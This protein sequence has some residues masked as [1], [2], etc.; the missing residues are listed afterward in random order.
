M[1]S[2]PPTVPCATRWPPSRRPRSRV[3]GCSRQRRSRR[4]CPLRRR[5]GEAQG[6]GVGSGGAG[7]REARL[8]AVE[9]SQLAAKG[10]DAAAEARLSDRE[11]SVEGRTPQDLVWTER[12][13]DAVLIEEEKLRTLSRSVGADHLP[14]R[15]PAAPER[16][17]AGGDPADAH[18][19]AEP[20]G[21]GQG[22][23]GR[24]R[25]LRPAERQ[26]RPQEVRG[27][28]AGGRDRRRVAAA[29]GS[30]ATRAAPSSP[31]TTKVS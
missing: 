25:L 17:L 30:A 4:T 20:D 7:P 12:D 15:Q 21:G 3:P 2:P 13:R 9:A 29:S 22:H 16:Q 26:E 19:S 10:R 23:A 24:G 8:A 31:T 14:R 5:R 28:G 1:R 27:P 18:R 6:R 11:G